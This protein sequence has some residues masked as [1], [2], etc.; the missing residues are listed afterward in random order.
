MLNA[1]TG[2]AKKFFYYLQSLVH[3]YTDA[4][5]ASFDRFPKMQVNIL[6]K[7]LHKAL[8]RLRK[9]EHCNNRARLKAILENQRR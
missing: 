9:K 5:E 6:Q 8:N 3:R 7:A 4:N 1:V 2:N